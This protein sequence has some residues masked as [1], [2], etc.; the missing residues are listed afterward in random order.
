MAPSD[1]GWLPWSPQVLHHAQPGTCFGSHPS[2][3][4]PVSVIY[5][6]RSD[7]ALLI[8]ELAR[9][10][11]QGVIKRC[12]LLVTP[13]CQQSAVPFIDVPD[14]DI[15]A[16]FAH[17]ENATCFNA[18]LSL[19]LLREELDSLETP[20]RIVVSGPEGFNGA[21][22]SMLTQLGV[23]ADAVTVLSG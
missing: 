13:A 11:R 15:A 19:P 8:P 10:C 9:L 14:T 17:L 22:K 5:S 3:T 20:H 23:D 4:Q 16:A 18:R 6:C 2:I 7:D 12:S 21:C 1:H